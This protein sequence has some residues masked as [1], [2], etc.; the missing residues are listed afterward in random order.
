[1]EEG[2]IEERREIR[3]EYDMDFKLRKI[4]K[5]GVLGKDIFRYMYWIGSWVFRK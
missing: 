4:V 3:K 1:M 5:E 2:L